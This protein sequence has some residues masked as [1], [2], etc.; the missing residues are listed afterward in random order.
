MDAL[1]TIDAT[2]RTAKF[3][4]AA[5]YHLHNVLKMDLADGYN[6]SAWWPWVKNYYGEVETGFFTTLPFITHVW[7]DQDLKA[8]LGY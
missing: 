3:K 8:Q 5:V 6:I 4:A 7:I 2:E 1:G